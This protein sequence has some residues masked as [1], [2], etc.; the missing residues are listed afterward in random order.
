MD[1]SSPPHFTPRQK[2]P[3]HFAMALGSFGSTEDSFGTSS[4]LP[5]F[6]QAQFLLVAISKLHLALANWSVVNL[7][8][9]G[10]PGSTAFQLFWL[11]LSRE[12][13]N[14][15]PRYQCK[16]WFLHSLLRASQFLGWRIFSREKVKPFKRL[17][18]QGP[19]NGCV[20]NRSGFIFYRCA[21]WCE[22]KGAKEL[23][24][25]KCFVSWHPGWWVEAIYSLGYSLNN[26]GSPHPEN[27]FMEPKDVAFWRRWFF[28]IPI[29]HP[30]TFGEQSEP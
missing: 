2:S 3:R 22:R 19:V 24:P 5:Q 28:H 15:S 18:F 14:E 10:R 11:A 26:P 1:P 16:D 4:P 6:C 25:K 23:E 20:R 29:T 21:S 12:W 17:C 8:P 13:G 9:K 30:L 7:T 27:G